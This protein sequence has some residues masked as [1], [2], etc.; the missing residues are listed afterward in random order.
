MVKR[1]I[2]T[3]GVLRIA[4]GTGKS[5]AQGRGTKSCA[6]AFRGGGAQEVRERLVGWLSV[7]LMGSH[8]FWFASAGVC[9][10]EKV[11]SLVFLSVCPLCVCVKA[12]KQCRFDLI[13]ICAGCFAVL[14]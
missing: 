5:G 10:P 13:T 7:A 9:R 2:Y 12:L 4:L 11:E 1:F 6:A 3:R 14:C 8:F